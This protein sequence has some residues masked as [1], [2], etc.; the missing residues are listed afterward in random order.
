MEAFETIEHK[1]FTIALHVDEDP[2][3]PRD[4][5]DHLGIILHKSNRYLLGDELSTEEEMISIAEREDVFVLPVF[6]HIHSGVVLSTASF[7]DVWDSGQCGIIYCEKDEARKEYPNTPEDKLEEFVW[8]RLKAEVE[9]FSAY[10]SGSVYG[11]V[12][13]EPEGIE[14]HSVWGFYS[15][16]DA[17]NDAKEHAEATALPQKCKVQE[18]PSCSG[19]GTEPCQLKLGHLLNR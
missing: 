12:M 18:L 5:F 14:E 15:T 13:T 10:L 9:E 2:Q 6:A 4:V 8:E 16:E 19:M 7:S 1:G 11:Y 17:L 3:N